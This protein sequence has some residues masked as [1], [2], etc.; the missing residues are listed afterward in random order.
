MKGRGIRQL[1]AACIC[2][3]AGEDV[4]QKNSKRTRRKETVQNKS[5][6]KQNIHTHEHTHTQSLRTLLS[7]CSL[8]TLLLES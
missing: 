3:E 4:R 2:V 7:L 8:F 1:K 5:K 6:L